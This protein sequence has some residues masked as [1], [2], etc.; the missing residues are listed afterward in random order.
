MAA[1]SSAPTRASTLDSSVVFTVTA[2]TSN[3]G[4]EPAFASSSRCRALSFRIQP[5]P[6]SM[7]SS[8]SCSLTSSQ[9]PSIMHTISSVPATTRSMSETSSWSKVG[10]T[11]KAPSTRPTRTPDTVSGNGTSLR[12]R[13]I[14]AP[15]MLRTSA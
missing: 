5:W 11:T 3:L 2:G 15:V 1:L 7:P 4:F 13:A 10:F 6:N 12:A 14:E 8:R 9:P